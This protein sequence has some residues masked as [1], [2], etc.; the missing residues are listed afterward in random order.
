MA[1]YNGL[2]SANIKMDNSDD[3]SRSYDI[4]AEFVVD[5]TNEIINVM[6]GKVRRENVTLATFYKSTL[7]KDVSW[8]AT[9]DTETEQNTI[10]TAVTDFID[11]CVTEIIAS[12]PLS[13]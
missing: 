7:R 13:I 5:G 12:N 3:V 8:M 1:T 2:A 4:S 10:N 6:N 11:S 9:V